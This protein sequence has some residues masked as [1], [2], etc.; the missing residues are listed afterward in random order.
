MEMTM[1]EVLISM[2]L[3]E[4]GLPMTK[5]VQQW[6]NGGTPVADPYAAPDSV[7][8]TLSGL[9]QLML[10]SET[11]NAG[12]AAA[13][14]IPAGTPGPITASSSN[15]AVATVSASS[16]ATPSSYA[17]NVTQLA[18]S[19]QQ[20]STLVVA[21]ANAALFAAGSF[22]L[23]SNGKTHTVQVAGGSLNQL[24]AGI[25]AAGA[26]VTAEAVH[27]EFGYQLRLTAN[28]T[29]SANSFSL[30]ASNDAPFNPWGLHLAQLGMTTTRA[31]QD[32]SYTVD[33]GA[34]Q[35]SASNSGI[36]LASG[37]NVTLTGTG[38]S[39]ISVT[40]TPAPAATWADVLSAANALIQNYNAL[41]GTMNNLSASGGAL[42]NDAT[43]SAYSAAIYADTQATYSGTT[44][45][46]LSQIGLTVSSES[47]VMQL[48]SNAL[49]TAF[50]A[51][52]A[53]TASV[54]REFA[55]QLRATLTQYAAPTFGS[56]LVSAAVNLQQNMAFIDGQPASSVNQLSGALKQYLLEQSLYGSNNPVAMPKI[57]IF[58]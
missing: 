37:V 10:A 24:V 35:T 30:A 7:K 50:N 18:Q 41:R 32:A 44:Y 54:V 33:G 28:H 58:A 16:A 2:R 19:M 52:T 4:A 9:G 36:A 13:E 45:N 14:N 57:N 1:G 23:T 56:Q 34:A 46:Q 47:A 17:L 3:R 12:L 15:S 11:A 5:N 43:A 26:G 51:N 38:A 29:G 22:E 53:E 55:Q 8:A 21:D 39:T 31:A 6:L 20:T 42:E 48:D 25:N 27:G 40:Q 49:Q